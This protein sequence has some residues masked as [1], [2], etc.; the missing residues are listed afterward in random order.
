MLDSTGPDSRLLLIVPHDAAIDHDAERT[1]SDDRIAALDYH[2]SPIRGHRF[3]IDPRPP[4]KGAKRPD[5]PCDF[6]SQHIADDDVHL[7]LILSA[8]NITACVCVRPRYYMR[9]R[10]SL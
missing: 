6:P 5:V 3:Q 10:G 9:V 7:F 8:A 1:A 2:L 4:P